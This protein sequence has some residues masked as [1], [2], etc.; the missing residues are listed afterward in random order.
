MKKGLV[1]TGGY[2]AEVASSRR[3]VLVAQIL[4]MVTVE[5]GRKN[6]ASD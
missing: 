4:I 3:S 2:M 6:E 1:N 5:D